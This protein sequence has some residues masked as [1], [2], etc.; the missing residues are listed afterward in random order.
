MTDSYYVAELY[1]T[2]RDPDCCDECDDSCT[3]AICSHW[4][5]MPN[6][7]YFR[8]FDDAEARQWL[9]TAYRPEFIAGIVEY[10]EVAPP[11]A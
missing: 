2:E 4:P 11:M 1:A 5:T 3:P 7:L 6:E 9:R 10:R 8:A